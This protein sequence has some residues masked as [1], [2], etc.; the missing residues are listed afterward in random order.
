MWYELCLVHGRNIIS[1][2]TVRHRCRMF[3]DGWT[4]FRDEEWSGRPSIVSDDLVQT[5]HQK[6][7]ERQ[8]FTISELSCELPQTVCTLLYEI[9][10]A[11][12]GYHKFCA[13]W[14]PKMLQGCTWKAKNGFSFHF[15][16]WYHKDGDK[17]LNHILQQ[18]AKAVF[19]L[20]MLKPKSSQSSK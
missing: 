18:V 2:G 10:T 11:R 16:K 7:C 20:W 13:R 6:I 19:H 5:V 8:H 1:E 3:K 4:N 17:F 9:T 14:V 15:L 12:T